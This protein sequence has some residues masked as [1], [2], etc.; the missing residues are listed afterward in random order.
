MDC[1]AGCAA[2]VALR[3]LVE[4]QSTVPRGTAPY[5]HSVPWSICMACVALHGKT[6]EYE[7][8]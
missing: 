2:C 8:R 3:I 7:A 6:Y 4:V 1:G 5:S